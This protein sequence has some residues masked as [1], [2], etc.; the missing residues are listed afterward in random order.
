MNRTP[1]RSK[2]PIIIPILI[3]AVLAGMYYKA[4]YVDIP[5]PDK[6]VHHFYQAY[7]KQDY[8]TVAKDLSVFWAV[9]LLPQYHQLTPAELLQNRAEIEKA[10]GTVLK[11]FEAN[12]PVQEGLSVEVLKDYTQTGAYSAV[13]VYQVMQQ[14]QAI[15]KEVALLIKEDSGFKI[16]NLS[17]LRDTELEL[18]T[19]YDLD[20]L[21]A[22]F[23][24]L[25]GG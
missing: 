11:G 3:V 22:S 20:Q 21:D 7:F 8:D 16:I 15:Q 1:A 12:Q 14:Q 13:V 24:E 19:N 10:T 23:K 18:I 17:P 6:T 2:V 25:L 5:S 9:N 4:A